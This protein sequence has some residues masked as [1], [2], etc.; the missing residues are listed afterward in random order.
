ML[1]VALLLQLPPFIFACSYGRD[2]ATGRA[3]RHRLHG[4]GGRT[5]SLG[6]GNIFPPSVTPRPALRSTQ[7]LIQLVSW[8][9]SSRMN[10]PGREANYSPPISS[11]VKNMWIYIQSLPLSSSCGRTQ[12]VK[13]KDNFTFYF[14]F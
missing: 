13:H 10:R 4:Q 3:T 2:M 9:L 1:P 11:E 5:S 14:F 12:L 8:T 7:L 6:S